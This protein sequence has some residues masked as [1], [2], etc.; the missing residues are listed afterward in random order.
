MTTTF[1]DNK[2]LRVL[3]IDLYLISILILYRC[4]ESS[5]SHFRT[6]NTHGRRSKN[7]GL[8]QPV[9]QEPKRGRIPKVTLDGEGQ[10]SRR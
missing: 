3:L 9:P 4:L 10:E 8:V 5:K 7:D 2:L 1:F 6:K